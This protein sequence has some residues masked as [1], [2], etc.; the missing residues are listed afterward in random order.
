MVVPLSAKQD[1]MPQLR[2][3]A[4]TIHHLAV[5]TLLYGTDFKSFDAGGGRAREEG[6]QGEHPY[7]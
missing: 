5:G 2:M 1:G 7:A 3:L 4:P 6:R